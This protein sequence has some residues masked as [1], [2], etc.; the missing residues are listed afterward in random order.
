MDIFT[1]R[2]KMREK[3]VN[4]DKTRL[5]Q[6]Q[7]RGLEML[8]AFKSLWRENKEVITIDDLQTTDFLEWYYLDE[9]ESFETTWVLSKTQKR[10][11]ELAQKPT[12]R[13]DT[14]EDTIPQYGSLPPPATCLKTTGKR[15]SDGRRYYLSIR[16]ADKVISFESV[17]RQEEKMGI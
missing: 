11:Q 6:L 5:Q 3:K 2:R 15:K 14:W 1:Q 16:R 9:E 10:F 4:D 7:K 13:F 17:A 8:E 12:G